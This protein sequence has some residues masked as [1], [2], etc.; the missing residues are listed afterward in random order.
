M[1]QKLLAERCKLI[2]HIVPAQADGY[3]LAVSK[4]GSHLQPAQPGETFPDGVKDLD[5]EGGKVLSATPSNNNTM[6]FFNAHLAD[7]AGIIGIT[8]NSVIQDQTNLTARYDFTIRRL[9][10]R[11]VDGKRISDLQPSDFWDI[12]ATG[13]E[14]K[15]AKIPSQNLIIDHI[16]RP[17]PN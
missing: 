13:L 17:S 12:S 6:S 5:P 9:E 7:L 16:E 8:S 15:R 2:V 1:L 10:P 3:A 14:L 11:D 4:R